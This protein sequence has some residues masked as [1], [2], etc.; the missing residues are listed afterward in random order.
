MN[1]LQPQDR[2]SKEPGD[3]RAAAQ[4]RRRLTDAGHDAW[5]VEPIVETLDAA[6]PGTNR[7][8]VLDL[9]CG[10]GF[11]LAALAGMRPVDGFGVDIS[12]PAIELAAKKHPELSW[13]VGNADRRL[14]FEDASF[15]FVMSVTARR[16]G[17]ELRRLLRADGRVLVVVPGEDDLAELREAVLGRAD[18]KDR[19]AAAIAELAVDLD[20]AS[21]RTI[22]RIERFAA[23]ETRDLL[24]A[25]YRGAR[26]RER[27]R[28]SG[29]GE[30]EITLSRELL[31]FRRR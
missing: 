3:S 5:M 18:R 6:A 16:N 8:S 31:V 29:I 12:V 7:P 26:S 23:S 2:R 14:P 10:E 25:T 21:R 22:R 30:M 4:A 1:L 17:R 27:E 11:L 13:I 28:A 9:G 20:L 15:D 24:A 19:A